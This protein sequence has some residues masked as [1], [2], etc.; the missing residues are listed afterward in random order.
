MKCPLKF[1][2]FSIANIILMH[3]IYFKTIYN[4][5]NANCFQTKL[6]NKRVKCFKLQLD[7]FYSK[8]FQVI[9]I[10]QQCRLRTVAN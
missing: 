2:K 7:M 3:T 5:Y 1:L 8:Q 9:S 4:W 10:Y 6:L